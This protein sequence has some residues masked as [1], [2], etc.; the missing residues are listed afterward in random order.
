M[1][2]DQQKT[3]AWLALALI[4]PV[5]SLGV[6][7]GMVWWP[8]AGVGKAIFGLS[9]LWIVLLPVI[10]RKWVEGQ[11]LSLSP[12]RQGG[13]LPALWTGIPIALMVFGAFL[14]VRHLGWV[15][16]A[17]V[18]ERA[19]LTG[20]AIPVVFVGGLIWSWLYLRFRSIWPC[21]LSH[22]CVDIPIFI[23]GW[24]IIFG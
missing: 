22:A 7:A 9:K 13:F 11:P 23:A 4:L 2:A 5:P 20:L 18:R 15:D 17:V 3:R 24:M 14:W 1:A 10:W 19:G 8:E 6:L 12:P 21:W 16:E